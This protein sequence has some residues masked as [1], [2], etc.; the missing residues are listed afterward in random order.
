[1]KNRKLLNFFFA[2]IAIILGWTLFKQF[3]FE[4]LKFEHTGLAI[5]YIITFALSI[6]FLIRNYKKRPEK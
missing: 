3:D 6:Y 1:M 2:I 5:I 4:N